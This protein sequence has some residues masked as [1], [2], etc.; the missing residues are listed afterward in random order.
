M[1]IGVV[2]NLVNSSFKNTQAKSFAG[3]GSP[4]TANE[5]RDT[6][7]VKGWQGSFGD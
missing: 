7:D 3:D 5:G 6:L 4:T 1:S 2:G